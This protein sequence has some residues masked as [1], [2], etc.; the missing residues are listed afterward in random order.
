MIP[1]TYYLKLDFGRLGRESV[2][3]WERATREDV[4][5]D[6]L[7]GDHGGKLLAVHC[8]D[9]D[10]NRWDDVT[11]EIA[12]EVFERLTERP[13]ADLLDF[14]EDKLGLVRGA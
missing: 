3:N 4:I 14:L 6:I 13:R 11:E 5:L 9:R 2:I 12:R 10:A 7:D 1:P 8:I